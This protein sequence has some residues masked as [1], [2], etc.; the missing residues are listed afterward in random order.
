MEERNE[1]KQITKNNDDTYISAYCVG[2][3]YNGVCKMSW[4]A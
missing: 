4:S 3:L 1:D 2:A